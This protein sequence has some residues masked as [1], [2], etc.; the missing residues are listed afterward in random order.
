MSN[1]IR[2]SAFTES[3]RGKLAITTEDPLVDWQ[4]HGTKLTATV[5]WLDG[6]CEVEVSTEYADERIEAFDVEVYRLESPPLRQLC[7]RVVMADGRQFGKRYLSEARNEEMFGMLR[8]EV[9]VFLEWHSYSVCVAWDRKLA[10]E[11]VGDAEGDY[12]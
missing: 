1:A 2:I 12:R 4:I 11:A 3:E 10:A 5:P 9:E 8:K 6:P 7:M